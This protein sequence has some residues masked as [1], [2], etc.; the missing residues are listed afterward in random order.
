MQIMATLVCVIVFFLH[1]YYWVE[2]YSSHKRNHLSF[3][4]HAHY[5]KYSYIDVT[6]VS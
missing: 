3:Y 4:L 6:Y 2:A 1:S 5:R